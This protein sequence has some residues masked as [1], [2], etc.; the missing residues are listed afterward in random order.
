MGVLPE[1]LREP[2]M[3]VGK[4]RLRDRLHKIRATAVLDD[5]CYE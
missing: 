5:E 4:T 1:K 2:N 3:R